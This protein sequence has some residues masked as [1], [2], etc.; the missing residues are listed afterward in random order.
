MNGIT[1]TTLTT[2]E[3]Q[4]V[5]VP[6]PL[7]SD[8]DAGNGSVRVTFSVPAGAGTISVSANS[9]VP[10]SVTGSGTNSV[11]LEGP[12]ANINNGL[13]NILFRPAAEFSGTVPFTITTGDNGNTGLGGE[14][15]DVDT[16]FITVNAVNDPPVS[17]ADFYTTAEDTT[18]VVGAPGV[19]ANDTD[20]DSPAFTAILLIPPASGDLVLNA[21]GSFTYTPAAN[22]SGTVFFT[23]RA[24][25]DGGGSP[26]GPNAGGSNTAKVTITVTPANDPPTANDDTYTVAGRRRA[27][28]RH[29]A[30]RAGRHGPSVHVRRSE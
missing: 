27:A 2:N 19:L 14:R 15:F 28:N 26:G 18:L 8:V 6:K 5:A 17:R 25:D 11:T 9:T 1:T 23:Y 16:I 7:I 20:V 12:I 13:A 3:D 22:F 24:I 10:L 21:D 4:A 30:H 29:P